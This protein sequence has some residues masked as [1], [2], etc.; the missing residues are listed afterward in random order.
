MLPRCWRHQGERARWEAS[1]PNWSSTAPPPAGCYQEAV[2]IAG[3]PGSGPSLTFV[4]VLEAKRVKNRLCLD[5]N[6]V[7]CDQEQEV[8]RL[9]GLGARRIDIGQGEQS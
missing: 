2:E 8:E 9:I 1:S 3:P 5:V 4:P 7:G 6:P